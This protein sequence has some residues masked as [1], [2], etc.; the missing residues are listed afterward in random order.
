MTERES[1]TIIGALKLWLD[2]CANAHHALDEG[3]PLV[4]CR[5]TTT[6]GAM[7]RLLSTTR[8]SSP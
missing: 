4:P 7:I 5:G 6:W 8:R 2:E 3:T 1:A